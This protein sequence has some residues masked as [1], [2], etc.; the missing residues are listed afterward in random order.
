[1]KDDQDVVGLLPCLDVRV[2]VCYES[3]PLGLVSDTVVGEEDA[4]A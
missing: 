2:H 4:G 1:M 3:T